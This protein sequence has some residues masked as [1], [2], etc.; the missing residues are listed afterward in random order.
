LTFR[1]ALPFATIRAF[2]SKSLTPSSFSKISSGRV[3]I[4]KLADSPER[5]TNTYQLFGKYLSLK[6]PDEVSVQELNQ[7]FWLWLRNQEITAHRSAIVLAVNSKVA[8]FLPGLHDANVYG[9]DEEDDDDE[10]E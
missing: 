8:T 3:A 10:E 4:E 6:G 7:R 1:L 9:N 2:Y 5:I